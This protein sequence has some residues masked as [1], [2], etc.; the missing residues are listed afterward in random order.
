MCLCLSY[1]FTLLMKAL[2][3]STFLPV[4]RTTAVLLSSSAGLITAAI[5]VTNHSMTVKSPT[6]WG[7]RYYTYY[8]LNSLNKTVSIFLSAC[9]V[10]AKRRVRVSHECI[11]LGCFFLQTHHSCLLSLVASYPPPPLAWTPKTSENH[12]WKEVIVR[13][14]A[15]HAYHLSLTWHFCLYQLYLEL[16][17]PFQKWDKKKKNKTIKYSN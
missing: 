9:V 10:A 6:V 17:C 15:S 13:E 14:Q 12:T 16:Y 2:C 11:F 1:H 3:L 7:K 8:D 5:Y 4:L